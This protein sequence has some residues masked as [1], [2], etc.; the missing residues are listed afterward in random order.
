MVALFGSPSGASHSSA[1]T[2]CTVAAME[3]GAVAKVRNYILDSIVFKYLLK[4]AALKP[5]WELPV[6]TH[7]RSEKRGKTN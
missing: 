4:A 5:F 7:L 6:A 3:K 1:A 2:V